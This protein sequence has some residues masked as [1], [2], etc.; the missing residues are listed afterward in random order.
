[1]F[2]FCFFFAKTDLGNGA[3]ELAYSSQD[4]G[5]HLVNVSINGLWCVDMPLSVTV[6][7]GPVLI[8]TIIPAVVIFCLIVLAIAL[9]IRKQMRTHERLLAH[10]RKPLQVFRNT[11]EEGEW[12]EG[13]SLN[14]SIE[15]KEWNTGPAEDD[16][17]H[18]RLQVAHHLALSSVRATS[19]WSLSSKA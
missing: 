14:N 5:T 13:G 11:G 4:L 8:G 3:Y 17:A 1:L 10:K 2:F 6:T 9:Y 7:P 19:S 12:D 16:D 18:H 15:L